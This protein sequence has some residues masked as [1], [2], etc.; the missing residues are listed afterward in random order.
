[1]SPR[2]A[3]RTALLLDGVI[4]LIWVAGVLLLVSNRSV[5]DA[6]AAFLLGLFGAT[7]AAYAVVGTLIARRQPSNPIGWLMFPTAAF[8]IV[9]LSA[10]E[11]AVHALAV[12]PG[13]LP[14]PGVV[15]SLAE[16]AAVLFLAS[17]ILILYLFPTG[18]TAGPRWGLAA[19]V[20]VAAASLDAVVTVLRPHEIDSLW[21]DRL[22]LI[23][24]RVHDPFGI[25]ALR[26]VGG[27][28]SAVGGWVVALG[29]ILAVASLFVR[30]RKADAQTRAQIRWLAYVVGAAFAWIL[31]MLLV[32]VIVGPSV[33]LDSVFWIVVTPLFSLGIPIAIGIAIVK[34]RLFDIDVV[35]GK[36]VV[37]GGLAVFITVVYVGIVFGV[38]QIVGATGTSPALS[39]VATAIVAVAFQPVRNRVQRFANR[40]V[41][42]KR[43]TPYEVLSEFSDQIG[44][45]YATEE[46]LPRMAQILAAGTGAREAAVWIV[47]ADRLRVEAIWP[48]DSPRSADVVAIEDIT[49]TGTDLAVPVRHRGE[50]LGALSVTKKA[51]DQLTSTERKLVDDLASQGGL[52]LRN[53]RLID[54][55]RASRRRIVAAQDERAKQLER[56]IHDGAQQQLVALAV[57]LR[58]AE[59]LA[60]R[61]PAKTRAMLSELQA[62]ATSA[63]EDLRDLA[64]GIYPPLL[65]DRGLPAA[66]EAQARKA[67]VPVSVES[68]GVGRYSPDVESAL[69]FC[70]LEA[71][72]NV[73]KYA[74]ATHAEVRLS[75]TGDELAFEVADDGDGFDP[76]STRFGSGL[77]GMADRLDAI[78]GMLEVTSQPGMGTTVTGHMPV[79]REQI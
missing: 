49:A 51:G 34:H 67:A 18:R 55:L 5:F 75:S 9:G 17:L 52:V 26:E 15:L 69:Y 13:S 11:Y 21:A 50:I 12:D 20:T 58:L 35:I 65:A 39:I 28:M 37:F 70:C 27:L 54:E 25:E 42:G 4:A 7:A 60:E 31:V 79:Q 1:V 47:D 10:T 32:N 77:Q 56:N 44:G 73:A 62:E 48:W 45:T 53:A 6:N 30:R 43:A 40:L 19:R 33:L 72:Q 66:L 64:R 22:E 57:K 36:T 38:G 63:L 16:P 3:A 71:L 24:L 29:A 78:G 61:E 2:I 46:L 76:S 68:D 14:V 8:L 23:P 41:Y 59:G 74:H